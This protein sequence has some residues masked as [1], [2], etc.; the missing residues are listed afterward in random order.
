MSIKSTVVTDNRIN[1]NVSPPSK[2]VPK[3]VTLHNVT[4]EDVGLGNV[5]NTSDLDKPISTLTQAALNSKAD[6]NTTYS[7]I[8]VDAN[9][10]TGIENLVANAPGQLDTLNELAAALNNEQN[11]A[12]NVTNLIATKA[13]LDSPPLTGFVGINK[14]TAASRTLDMDGHFR[15]LISPENRIAGQ[16][17]ALIK[18]K[19]G[20]AAQLRVAGPV[21]VTHD[22]FKNSGDTGGFGDN[23]NHFHN[24]TKINRITQRVGEGGPNERVQEQYYAIEDNLL[25]NDK[26]AFWNWHR[27][28]RQIASDDVSLTSLVGWDV[29]DIQNSLNRS[30]NAQALFPAGGAEATTFTFTSG[31]NPFSLNDLLKIKI[32]IDFVGAIV[33][34]TLFAKVTA[35]PTTDTAT[36][37]LYGGNYKSTNEVPRA[38]DQEDITTNFS[39][40]KI[41]TSQYMA[42]A[43]GTGIAVSG[44][45]TRKISTDTFSIAFAS[46]H[47]LELN[48]TVTIFTDSTGGFQAAEVAFVKEVITTT[49]AKFV[50]GRVFEPAGNLA[51]TS[52]SSSSVVGVL[53]G[54]LDGLHR[55]TAG[56]IL[57]HYNA[58]NQGR[59]KSYQIGPGTEVGADCI[60]IGKNVYNKDASTIKI[61]YDN[62][63]LNIKSDGIDVTGALEISGDLTIPGKIIHKDDPN[64]FIDFEALD[65]FSI[66]TN[67]I[68]RFHIG[69]AG[70]VGIATNPSNKLHVKSPG[71]IGQN[72]SQFANATI[73]VEND[74]ANLYI[75]GNEVVSDHNLYLQTTLNDGFISLAADDGTGTRVN[76]ANASTAGFAIGK[77]TGKATKSL[78]VTGGAI[79]RGHSEEAQPSITLFKPNAD[80]NI[81]QTRLTI[82]TNDS[83]AAFEIQTYNSDNV[84]I[85]NDYRIAKNANGADLHEFNIGNSPRLLVEYT[86][87]SVLEV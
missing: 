30:E 63:M 86:G 28:S 39:V 50:Y 41:D 57:F 22:L 23:S 76:V 81:R 45:S 32:D 11:F 70:N 84:F 56:D 19:S 47:G 6:Q 79:F 52:I 35:I 25:K 78:D 5:D 48:D 69:P 49:Q 42:L 37:V 44:D 68:E 51:L 14:T 26:A 20:L 40:D 43:T 2:I 55:F 77:G 13:P 4:K 9:I 12:T 34:A 8:E 75:D 62:E 71:T 59:Y 21:T 1:A 36:V 27:I 10:E 66:T 33:A 64:T 61:G 60:A 46:N 73:R 87:I 17:T 53:R 3:H 31:N 18:G 85:S 67:N 72:P 58:D 80:A 54:T 65:S 24:I 16:S 74:T 38:D 7:K 82:G 83:E 29:S 15:L